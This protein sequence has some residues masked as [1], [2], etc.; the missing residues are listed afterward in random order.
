M[1]PTIRQGSRSI[2][3]SSARKTRAASIEAESLEKLVRTKVRRVAAAGS[4]AV[5]A[6]VAGGQR[7]WPRHAVVATPPR[8]LR[9]GG[10]GTS[11]WG[12]S[13]PP[14]GC[15]LV[16]ATYLRAVWRCVRALA[17]M[18]GVWYVDWYC[19][20]AIK[21]SQRGSQLP[22]FFVSTQ[23]CSYGGFYAQTPPP[24]APRE[25][26][27]RG[28]SPRWQYTPP[29][30]KRS[31]TAHAN[32]RGD[33]PSVHRR[34]RTHRTAVHRHTCLARKGG[35]VY[36]LSHRWVLP[37]RLLGSKGLN[38]CSGVPSIARRNVLMAY[39]P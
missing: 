8:Q 19:E 21:V 37:E 34:T 6:A 24:R 11:G 25:R 13:A 28:A 39:A 29:S 22:G 36:G 27:A 26:G 3:V 15:G 10:P 33:L 2:A 23:V 30:C 16:E 7:G 38:S 31:S 35:E 5:G 17:R 20:L 32:T 12:S 14:P 9:E 1:Q 4:E 18:L